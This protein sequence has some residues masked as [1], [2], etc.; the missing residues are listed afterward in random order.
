M[1]RMPA[2]E[3]NEASPEAQAVFAQFM[4]ERGNVPNLFRTLARR[5]AIMSTL[6]A[7]L[8]AVLTT[9]TVDIR[10]KELVIVR[11]SQLNACQY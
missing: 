4:A 5:P 3:P 2:L 9:G 8:K 1:P 7:H 6:A 11:V 10:L